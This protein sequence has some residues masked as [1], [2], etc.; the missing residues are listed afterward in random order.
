MLQVKTKDE[1]CAVG[2]LIS[3]TEYA[4]LEVFNVSW[5]SFYKQEII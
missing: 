5:P 3:V 1:H 2:S 4:N